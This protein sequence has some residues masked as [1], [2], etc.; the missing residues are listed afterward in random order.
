MGRL[1][2]TS[3]SSLMRSMA[4]DYKTPQRIYAAGSAGLFRSDDA[5]QKWD[6]ASSGFK[7]EPLAVALNP[8]APQAVFAVA[9]DSTV[10]QSDDGATTWRMLESRK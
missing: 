4:V 10:W 2:I 3:G 1:P 6:A 5:G 9:T 7:G 8:D